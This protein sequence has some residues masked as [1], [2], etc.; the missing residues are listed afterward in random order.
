MAQVYAGLLVNIAKKLAVQSSQ[1]RRTHEARS[2]FNQL[3]TNIIPP[4]YIFLARQILSAVGGETKSGELAANWK[5][6]LRPRTAFQYIYIY[7]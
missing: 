1:A 4:G 5:R 7:E 2:Y 6:H 3:N